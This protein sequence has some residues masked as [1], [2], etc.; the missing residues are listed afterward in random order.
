MP[1]VLGLEGQL[2]YST[3]ASCFALLRCLDIIPVV[4]TLIKISTEY[5][6][7]SNFK[8]QVTS[9]NALSQRAGDA[10]HFDFFF[11]SCALLRNISKYHKI[12]IFD[13]LP[14]KK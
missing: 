12:L 10:R 6:P 11:P 1:F 13:R 5:I 3:L 7:F 14:E 8:P 9:F 4:E 2:P